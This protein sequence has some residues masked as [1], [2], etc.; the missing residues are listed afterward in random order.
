MT[1]KTRGVKWAGSAWS[2]RS[3]SITGLGQPSP[4]D[5]RAIK[6]EPGPNM[7]QWPDGSA[8]PV[9]Q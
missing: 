4:T 9:I 6:F 8:L 1:V 3:I 7:G 2:A 5:V